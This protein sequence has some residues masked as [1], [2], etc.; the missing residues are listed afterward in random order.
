[1]GRLLGSHP[2]VALYTELF[3]PQYGYVPEM[4]ATENIRLLAEKGLIS[5]NE[6]NASVLGKSAQ[7][8]H[9]GDKR[10]N[11]LFSAE[12]SLPNLA[13]YETRVVHLVRNIYDVAASHQ[14]KFEAGTWSKNF[15]TAVSEANRNNRL[16]RWLLTGPYRTSIVI[17]DYDRFWYSTKNLRALFR[18]VQLDESGLREGYLASFV[19]IARARPTQDYYRLTTAQR[20]YIDREYDFGRE[21]DIKRATPADLAQDADDP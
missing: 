14:K 20:R 9:V 16:A 17:V 19:H 21:R 2:H 4:L 8:T 1:M 11:F 12:L 18:H 5:L 6:R 7:C 15:R 13:P 10:P 3:L